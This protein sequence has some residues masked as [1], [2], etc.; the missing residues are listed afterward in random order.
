MAKKMYKSKSF[1][2]ESILA[3]SL[4]L[5]SISPIRNI[6]RKDGPIFLFSNISDL[7]D[8]ELYLFFAQIKTKIK[9]K[10][11]QTV[12]NPRFYFRCVWISRK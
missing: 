4:H 5:M 8:R 1:P 10:V 6:M 3:E 12:H 2:R 9:S 11:D 7:K